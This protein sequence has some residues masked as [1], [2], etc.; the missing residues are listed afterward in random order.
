MKKYREFGL[1]VQSMVLVV[2]MPLAASEGPAGVISQ[3]GGIVA[4]VESDRTTITNGTSET[5][6]SIVE[7]GDSVVSAVEGG[8][9]QFNGVVDQWW[10]QVSGGIEHLLIVDPSPGSVTEVVVNWTDLTPELEGLDSV[11]LRDGEGIPQFRYGGLS[12][13][14]AFHRPLEAVFAVNGFNVSIVVETEGAIGPITIDPIASQLNVSSPGAVAFGQAIATGHLNS[15]SFLDVVVGQPGFNSGQGRVF[16][17][18][19]TATGISLNPSPFAGTPGVA[20]AGCGRN[21][22]I[23]DVSNPPD[24]FNDVIIACS[25]ASG[26][27][28]LNGGS[29]AIRVHLN[30]ATNSASFPTTFN[31]YDYGAP[32]PT[33]FMALALKDINS[34]GQSEIFSVSRATTGVNRLLRFAF[35]FEPPL[36]QIN[37]G[38]G[39]WSLASIDLLSPGPDGVVAAGEGQARVFTGNGTSAL[40]TTPTLVPP[41]PVAT[42]LTLV[43]TG[44]ISGDGVGDVVIALPAAFSS[45]GAALVYPSDGFNTW[46]LPPKGPRNNNKSSCI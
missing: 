1:L 32:F 37:L 24:G 30:S 27:G 41:T 22:V 19:G 39:V 44:D 34:D 8:V 2:S 31:M 35:G 26:T 10:L 25:R 33:E 21:V 13:W 12:V 40:A 4:L 20:N 14:D 23:G 6:V 16:I 28:G 5:S 29:G 38:T 17:F 45:M 11:L 15:D 42:G 36:Q 7:N 46:N 18:L 9:G 43:A 3:S